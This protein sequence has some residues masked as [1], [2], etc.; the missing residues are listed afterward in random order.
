MS[1]KDGKPSLGSKQ[2]LAVVLLTTTVVVN[3]YL[4]YPPSHPS[5]TANLTSG[6]VN[7]CLLTQNF[8]Q[9]R[10]D[11]DAIRVCIFYNNRDR[12][13]I[14]RT[15]STS[16]SL[17]ESMTCRVRRTI[18]GIVEMYLTATFQGREGDT[19]RLEGNQN[20]MTAFMSVF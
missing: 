6:S 5:S 11:S 16:I 10:A 12:I 15:G 8:H 13:D 1:D 17:S 20:C 19:S 7:R 3:A 14:R 18:T 4:Y 2:A 9:A